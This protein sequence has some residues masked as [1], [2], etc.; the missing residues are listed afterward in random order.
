MLLRYG[1]WGNLF[2]KEPYL[3]HLA[4]C[5]SYHPYGSS[6]GVKIYVDW[7]YFLVLPQTTDLAWDRSIT[8]SSACKYKAI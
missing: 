4:G 5:A 1:N 3:L 2:I 8:P 6:L 7:G